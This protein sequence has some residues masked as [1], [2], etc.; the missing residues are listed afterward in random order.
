MK[1]VYSGL[2][3]EEEDDDSPREKDG[4]SPVRIDNPFK[5]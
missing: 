4:N 3:D 2:S 1:D 5:Q